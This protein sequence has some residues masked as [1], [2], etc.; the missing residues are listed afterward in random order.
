VDALITVRQIIPTL[1]GAMQDGVQNEGE[2]ASVA[3]QTRF[4][5]EAFNP[6]SCNLS[7]ATR[8]LPCGCT[9]L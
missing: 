2:R 6:F 9:W 3:R 1:F 4:R 5:L 7:F 8:F